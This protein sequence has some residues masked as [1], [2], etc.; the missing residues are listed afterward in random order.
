MK[1][2]TDSDFYQSILDNLYDGVYFVDCERRI[3]FWSRG[4][5]RITGYPAEEVV[6]SRCAEGIL[7][8]VPSTPLWG[9]GGDIE[10]AVETFSDNTAALAATQRL[11]ELSRELIE[12]RL[13]DVG[14]RRFLDMKRRSARR[15][16]CSPS[17]LRWR[18]T[19]V[20]WQSPC[21]SALL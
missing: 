6:G 8:H 10:G 15:Y 19:V 2:Q 14:N 11:E 17:D 4:A 16:A 1:P 9:P 21:P 5:E 7:A 20:R 18:R 3:T 12:D 13:T